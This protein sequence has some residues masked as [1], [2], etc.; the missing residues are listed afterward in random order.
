MKTFDLFAKEIGFNI[1]M[2]DN[3]VTFADTHYNTFYITKKKKTK[4]REITSPSKELKSI[5]RWVLNNYFNE[6]AISS[7]ANGFI[8]GR[9]IKRNAQFHLNKRFILC[10]DI[11]DFFPSISQ[12]MVFNALS[13]VF[14]D[15]DLTLKLSK[16]CT[17][18]R[19]LPQGAPTSPI[20]SNIVFKDLDELFTTFCNTKLVVY[21]R[22]ADDL[23]FSSDTKSSLIEVYSYINE[24]LIKNGFRIN[25][26]KTKY[27]SGKG[28]MT[29]T[30][31]NLNEG[32]LTISQSVKRSVRSQIF[33][34]IVKKDMTI[35]TN[36][37]LGYL[38]FIKDIEPD[39]HKKLINY[40]KK[41]KLRM[42]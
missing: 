25:T 41:L 23:V 3:F 10:V 27:F 36:S 24:Q 34:L 32:K 6:I 8:K 22:Y 37:I 28:R 29:V 35:N 21:S 30:G 11:K 40:I 12:K 1:Q 31:I 16:L 5:Q 42:E 4:K 7:R 13:N 2:L 39:Y 38:S 15:R 17:Y 14:D 20:L 26:S 18:K 33:R 19:H 9:G